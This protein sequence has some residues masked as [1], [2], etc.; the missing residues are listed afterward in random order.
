MSSTSSAASAVT[1][2]VLPQRATSPLLRSASATSSA[3]ASSNS[4][5]LVCQCIPTCE[6]SVLTEAMLNFS[7]AGRP[8]RQPALGLQFTESEPATASGPTCC[9]SPTNWTRSGLS[10]SSPRATVRGK[11]KSPLVWNQLAATLPELNSRLATLVRLISVG[12]CSFLPTPV[13]RDWRSPGLRS[14]PRLKRSRGQPLPETIGSR[15]HP[16][17]C[18]WLMGFPIGWTVTLPSKQSA[19]ATRQEWQP[20]SAGQF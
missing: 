3:D 13:S 8:A 15:V 6:L 9:E 14:H 16:E 10:W 19:T 18:E 2:S 1:H 20:S 11:P 12:A 7:S 17:L 5:S 4:A